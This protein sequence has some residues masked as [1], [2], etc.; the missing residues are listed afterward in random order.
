[1]LNL[2]GESLRSGAGGEDAQSGQ[3]S[4]KD[5]N[6]PFPIWRWTLTMS[7]ERILPKRKGISGCAS[8]RALPATA[9]GGK[10]NSIWFHCAVNDAAMSIPTRHRHST[11]L[12]PMPK[13]AE[14]PADARREQHATHAL[15]LS[16]SPMSGGN[17]PIAPPPNGHICG[18]RTRRA[19]FPPSAWRPSWH[20]GESGRLG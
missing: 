9:H 6:W 17:A 7:G 11:T 16:A 12:P 1:M 4:E 10:H 19:G 20:R 13:G 18:R 8:R 3:W 14:P 2:L 5:Q 15:S